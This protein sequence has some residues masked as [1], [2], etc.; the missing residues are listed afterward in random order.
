MT[1]IKLIIFDLDGVLI[2][3]KK[4]HE[5][6]FIKSWN[7]IYNDLLISEKFH[8]LYLEGRNTIG[9]LEFLEN[10]YSIKVNKNKIFENKQKYTKDELDIFHYPTKFIDIFINLKKKG[11]LLACASNSINNTVKYVLERL[12]IK[13]N[14][15][16]ILTNEDVKHPKPNPEIY[17]KVMETCKVLPNETII[18]EDSN[19]GL[20]AAYESKAHVVKVIDSSDLNESFINTSIEYKMKYKPWESDPNWKITVVIP[21]AGEGSRFK[22]EG[23]TI[24]KPLIP[25]QDK[26]MIQWVLDN[27]KSKNTDLANKIEYHL[28]VRSDVVDKLKDI[29]NVY[30]HEIPSLTE[31]P[32]S[33]VL[34]IRSSLENNNYPLLIANSD[35]FLEWDFDEFLEASINPEYEGCISTFNQPDSTDLKW[36][37]AKI[38]ENGLVT[39]VAEKEYISSNATTGIYF[40]KSA[41]NFVK[42]VDKMI[43]KNDRVKN[44][45]YVGPVYN[46]AIQNNDKIRIFN[47]K[48]MWGLGVP[49]DLKKFMSDYLKY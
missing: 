7:T 41:S 28:C 29:S 44:E 42:Y 13:E 26:P 4:I 19:I 25:I 17:I 45:F 6:A 49:T 8:E 10:M 18:F 12:Q 47:C 39:K 9:K 33:T 20:K 32:A 34:T 46:Y 30:L 15:D 40:W 3:C 1:N 22:I 27:L 48:K 38:D 24:T 2:D 31:G 11:Y 21:M 5:N 37:Y 43:E 35:Q 36:S 16:C 23:Y 14:F